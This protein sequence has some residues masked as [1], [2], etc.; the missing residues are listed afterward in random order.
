MG[1]TRPYHHVEVTTLREG[2]GYYEKVIGKNVEG[3]GYALS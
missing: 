2:S 3:S 1:S